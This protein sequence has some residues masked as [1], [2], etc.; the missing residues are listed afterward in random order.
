MPGTLLKLLVK[1]RATLQWKT[2]RGHESMTNEAPEESE[3]RL[4]PMRGRLAAEN[5]GKR[6]R[7]YQMSTKQHEWLAVETPEERELR[8][9]C[10]SRRC[11]EQ[12]F[13]RLQ[14]PLFQ[15]C[16]IQAKIKLLNFTT[17]LLYKPGHAIYNV[18]MVVPVVK[19]VCIYTS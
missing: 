6:E 10:Y 16:S 5:P 19:Q 13:V 9:E 1:K 3:T 11:R 4:Q 14:L 15:Q 18:A 2:T 7:L 12:K 17:I 8:L